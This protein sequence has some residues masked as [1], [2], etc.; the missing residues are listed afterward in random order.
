MKAVIEGNPSFSHVHIDLEPGEQLIAESGAMQSM[1]ASLDMKARSNGGFLSGLM[2]KWFGG[3]TFFVNEFSNKGSVPMRVTIAQNVPGEIRELNLKNDHDICLQRGSWLASE[4]DV[5]FKAVW[6]GFVSWFSGE[7]LVKLK[8]SGDGR[9]WFGAYGG[10]IERK[11]EGE[12]KIDDGHLVA[13]DPSL[14]LKIALAG[15]L[16]SSVLGGEGFVTKVIG[17]GTVYIQTRSIKG[18]A[19]WLNPKFR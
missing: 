13:Y 1:S 6:A 12:L 11:V 17:T 8:A 2:K 3:E 7:G 16:L 4:G 10:I 14:K 5:R 9:I 15:D 18:L 19:S